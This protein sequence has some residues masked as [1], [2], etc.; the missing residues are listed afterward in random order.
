MRSARVHSSWQ[1]AEPGREHM[2][3]LAP[4]AGCLSF[5]DEGSGEAG[6]G[7]EISDIWG[8]SNKWLYNNTMKYYE[9]IGILFGRIIN[10]KRKQWKV[11]QSII[12]LF[13]TI[14][15]FIVHTHPSTLCL[16]EQTGREGHQQNSSCY[17]YLWF[18]VAFIFSFRLFYFIYVCCNE[19]GLQV[20]PTYYLC[21]VLS[22]HIPI[23][24]VPRHTRY[25]S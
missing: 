25:L 23:V 5:L 14:C 1:V 6:G 9:A 18:W 12:F 15:M 10:Q 8:K 3:A 2:W 17:S 24:R 7:R 20:A 13:Y 4:E 16:E 19:L 11:R 22:V 21:W